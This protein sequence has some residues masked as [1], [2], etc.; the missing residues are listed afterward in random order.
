[1]C[2]TRN[3]QIATETEFYIPD[4]NLQ[5]K[6]RVLIKTCLK[7]LETVGRTTNAQQAIITLYGQTV[8]NHTGI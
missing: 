3:S 5:L 4:T 1:M 7:M 8:L 2:K 6:A